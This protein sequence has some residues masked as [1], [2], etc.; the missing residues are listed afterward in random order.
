MHSASAPA[1]QARLAALGPDKPERDEILLAFGQSLRLLRAAAR[2]SQDKLA[3]RCFLRH[4]E[5]SRLERGG[6]MPSLTVLFMLAHT[7]G[8][9]V[10]QLTDG[11]AAPSRTA[12]K[13]QTLSLIDSQPGI[14]TVALAQD[15]EVPSWYVREL[16]RCLEAAGEVARQPPGWR[17]A[18]GVLDGAE[19]ADAV[20]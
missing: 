19:A 5:I 1:K 13:G 2:L 18:G 10:A 3:R 6:A 9:S 17:R 14:S 15:M 11:L 12:T 8:A 7:L 16:I 20:G 4:D